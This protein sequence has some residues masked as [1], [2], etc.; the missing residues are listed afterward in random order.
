[1]NTK[2][3]EKLVEMGAK[4]WQKGSMKRLY[5][6]GAITK[7]VGLYVARY[8]SGNISYAELN[9]EKISNSEGYRII[10]AA[11]RLYID[12]DT[13]KICSGKIDPY[14]IDMFVKAITDL[15]NLITAQEEKNAAP[16]VET[17]TAVADASENVINSDDDN[18]KKGAGETPAEGVKM[19]TKTFSVEYFDPDFKSC[20]TDSTENIEDVLD[21]M[22]N[23]GAYHFEEDG[24]LYPSKKDEDMVENGDEWKLINPAHVFLFDAVIHDTNPAL[25]A[26]WDKR[27]SEMIEW[28]ETAHDGDTFDML[29]VEITCEIESDDDDDEE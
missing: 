8:N 16:V 7:L 28:G 5:L 29:G 13:M 11:D 9:G 23:L 4:E 25:K 6:N 21:D 18:T 14:Y 27:F 17:E 22:F 15:D 24:K 26:A 2:T 10:N 12:L 3:L 1:M 19:A 20:Q